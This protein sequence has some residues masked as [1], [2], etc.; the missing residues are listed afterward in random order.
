MPV[1]EWKI[2]GR[3]CSLLVIA[4]MVLPVAAATEPINI[5]LTWQGDPRYSIT[6][7]WMTSSESPSIVEYGVGLPYESNVGGSP[8][9]FHNVNITGLKPGTQYHY[10]CGSDSNWSDDF[11][12]R[13][14]PADP[15][16]P[17]T[18][19][20]FGDSRSHWDIWGEC[21]EAVLA[22][23]PEF[24]LHTGDIVR[25]GGK[26]D[27]WNISF[28]EAE[29]L[30]SRRVV[31]PAIGNHERNDP[32]YYNQ[33]ALPHPEDWYSFDYGNAHFIALS[34]EKDMTGSQREWLER[35]LSSTNATWKFV[36]Y[37]RPMYSSGHHG[38]AMRVQEAWIDLFDEYHVDMVFN[39]HDHDY[40]RSYPMFDNWLSDSPENGTIHVVT[41][42]AGASLY[43]LVSPGPWMA[44]FRKVNHYVFLTINGTELR[45][46]ARLFNGTVF[47]DVQL[48]KAKLPDLVVES[49]TTNPTYPSPGEGTT[50][51]AFVKNVGRDESRDCRVHIAID[52]ENLSTK[53]LG[54]LL[55]GAS[56]T[57]QA[58]W[59]PT[60]HGTFNVTAWA[61]CDD[62][63]QEGIW[64][65]NNKLGRIV[66]VS[67]P[68]PDLVVTA[69]GC[70][71]IMPRV[72]ETITVRVDVGNEG[73]G[74]SGRFD[75]G[76]NLNGI[77]LNI[78]ACSEGL[79]PGET[80]R[81]EF[82]LIC[83][84]GDW[85][86]AV[87]VDPSDGVDELYEDNNFA[88][89]TFYFRDFLKASSAYLSQGLLEG[90][91]V[92][93]YY[94]QSEGEI[95]S[96]SSTCVVVWGMNGRKKPL[97]V[98]PPD[99]VTGDLFETQMK[100]VSEGIWFAVLPTS[101][102]MD[103]IDLMFEDRQVLSR[104]SDDN[105]GSNWLIPGFELARSKVD[106]LLGAIEDAQAFGVDVSIYREEVEKSNLSL[107]AGRYM[108]AMKMLENA[109]DRCRKD[110]CEAIFEAATSE[111]E[112]ALGEGIDVGRAQILLNA[113][114]SQMELCNYQGSNQYSLKVITMIKEA[115]AQIS[116][117]KLIPVLLIMLISSLRIA[118]GWASST[119]AVDVDGGV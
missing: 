53:Q 68:K 36:F 61:D 16:E 65:K 75:I 117:I 23:G 59:Y 108:E 88:N 8:A 32:L 41:A 1:K 102:E 63:V 35:D 42:G 83:V 40:E 38:C 27:E 47:D 55:P 78:S 90:E 56:A 24:C 100:K 113:A 81:F 85:E 72:G 103:W 58:E 79:A 69:L 73:S 45:M 111:Y 82:P 39:G 91:S 13:T 93:I 70:D 99:T 52:G 97:G 92:I 89:R 48:S 30:L 37:H 2:K 114:R 9:R 10:R 4:L 80:L 77:P 20:V 43:S 33:F 106:G 3:Y 62:V 28:K 116:E 54:S 12:F 50:I 29:A 94:N 64:E 95:P 109:T 86:I 34:T 119:S 26:Q 98:N 76:I 14:A 105:N 96:N 18:F 49:I 71:K 17:F 107:L 57:V 21:A 31:M 104:F 87:T 66:L 110:E 118:Y 11:T 51:V 67:E 44:I 6:I 25:D 112:T 101:E 74:S 46:E 19:V 5:H 60:S 22:S 115:R 7:S 84:W 15:K